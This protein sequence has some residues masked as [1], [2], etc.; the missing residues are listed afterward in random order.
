MLT[1]DFMQACLVPFAEDIEQFEMHDDVQW[2]LVV[3]KDVCYC[4]SGA[5]KR[6]AHKVY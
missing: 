3:E 1:T 2:I 4:F 5:Q 6:S